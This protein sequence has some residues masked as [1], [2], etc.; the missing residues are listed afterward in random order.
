[1]FESI[2]VKPSQVLKEFKT[3][4]LKA[5]EKMIGQFDFDLNNLVA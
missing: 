3:D 4:P 5:K 2:F 1:M